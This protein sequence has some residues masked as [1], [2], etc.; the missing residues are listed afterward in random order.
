MYVPARFMIQAA[1]N[2]MVSAVV[3]SKR[4]AEHVSG[5]IRDATDH[6]QFIVD[7]DGSNVTERASVHTH[8]C[9]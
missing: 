4:F 9:W 5:H 6:G 7:A 2:S 8:S 3:R 1:A